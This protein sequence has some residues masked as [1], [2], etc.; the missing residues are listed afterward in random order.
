METFLFVKPYTERE[1]DDKMMC[2]LGRAAV[3]AQRCHLLVTLVH[4]VHGKNQS[5]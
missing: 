2:E 1:I 3:L 4:A 5:V